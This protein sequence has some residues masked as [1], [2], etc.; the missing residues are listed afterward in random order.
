[1]S[2]AQRGPGTSGRGK[3][4]CL[5]FREPVGG[6][7]VAGWEA[8]ELGWGRSPGA[9]GPAQG[10]GLLSTVG[11]EKAPTVSTGNDPTGI[12]KRSGGAARPQAGHP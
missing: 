4:V 12:F 7:G 8:G 9:Y 2:R 5:E 10:A 3:S 1:M 11:S 6:R